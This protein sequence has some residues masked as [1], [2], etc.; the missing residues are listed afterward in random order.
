MRISEICIGCDFKVK[1]QYCC[2]SHPETGKTKVLKLHNGNV[3]SACP[4]LDEEG[5]CMDYE[6]R[7]SDCRD[8][9]DCPILSKTD[10]CDLLGF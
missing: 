4:N 7:P 9:I 10:L 8:Y 2:Y 3:V 1:L 5:L 6:N